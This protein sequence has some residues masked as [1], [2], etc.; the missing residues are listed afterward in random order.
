MTTTAELKSAVAEVSRLTQS[1]EVL[2]ELR[3]WLKM[4]IVEDV[5]Y[6]VLKQ[7]HELSRVREALHDTYLARGEFIARTWTGS[8][9][10]G[11][12]DGVCWPV[13]VIEAGFAIG[14]VVGL[15]K[16][17]LMHGYIPQYIPVEVL[18]EIARAAEGA[19]FR[20]R[21]PQPKDTNIELVVG[22]VS[23]A[24]VE[25]SAVYAN[26]K[27]RSEERALRSALLEARKAKRLDLFGLSIH[28]HFDVEV[29][30][31][32]G[33]RAHVARSLKRLNGIDLVCNAAAGGR[34]LEKA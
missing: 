32:E 5:A 11:D 4:S 10:Y 30:T 22:T 20:R 18:P 16:P 3:E 34:F 23:G 31:V 6:K 24:R 7:E 15:T 17:D 13:K 1:A 8:G 25:G 29:G 12:G 27:L 9:T 19:W 28:A 26:V 21:H 14:N 2:R 33:K